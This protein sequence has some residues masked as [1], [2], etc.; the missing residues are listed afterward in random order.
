MDDYS[1]FSRYDTNKYSMYDITDCSI[2]GSGGT[3]TIYLINENI[4][5]AVPNEVDGLSL[6]KVWP[7]I[8]KEELEISEKIESLGVPVLKLNRCIV[9]YLG[10][11]LHT[12]SS[13]PF[14]SHIKD[15]IYII[16]TK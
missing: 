14:E 6:V 4:C 15:G 10:E 2:I 7:R 11:P 8:I 12:I 1:E 9:K 5:V 3:K 13:K 16:D